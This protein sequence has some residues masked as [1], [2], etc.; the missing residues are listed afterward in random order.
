VN[1][2]LLG[3]VFWFWI[4]MFCGKLLLVMY[5][6]KSPLTPVVAF[7]G[8]NM[9]WNILFSPFGAET[10]FYT[11]YYLVFLMFAHNRLLIKE[12]SRFCTDTPQSL[13]IYPNN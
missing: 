13:R 4:M 12:G 9:L 5:K 7:V 11:A 1:S 2:G 8:F 6:T 10:R 3:A